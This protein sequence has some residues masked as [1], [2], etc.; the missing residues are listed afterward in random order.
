MEGEVTNRDVAG[1]LAL[2][3]R[4]LEVAGEDRHRAAAYA[5]A[6]R[7][8]EHLFLAG[9]DEEALTRIPGIGVRIAGQIRE[10]VESGSF[11]ELDDLKAS[12]PGSVIELLDIPGVGPR[13]LHALWKH[14]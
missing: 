4:L 9:L 12:V 10:I 7:Q 14:L 8:V 5:R 11:Q 3:G 6:A 2:M 1:R 13:T